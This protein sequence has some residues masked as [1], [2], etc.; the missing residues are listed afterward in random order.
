MFTKKRLLILGSVVAVVAI[1]VAAVFLFVLKPSSSSGNAALTQVTPANASTIVGD[2]KVPVFILFTTST[3]PAGAKLEAMMADAQSQMG[4]R[5]EFVVV[6]ITKY[7]SLAD[8]IT[9]KEAPVSVIVDPVTEGT[10]GPI[11]GVPTSQSQFDT[12]VNEAATAAASASSTSSSS[13]ATGST[14]STSSTNG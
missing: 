2:S 7:P 5:V 8:G 6:N 4:S 1:A 12:F 10:V 3:S 13:A 9:A 11:S 14:S